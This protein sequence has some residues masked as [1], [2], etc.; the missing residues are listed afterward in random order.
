ML[1]DLINGNLERLGIKLP[2]PEPPVGSYVPWKRC[3]PTLWVSGQIP[4]IGGKPVLTGLLG[5]DVDVEDG[6]ECA[7]ICAVNAL[8]WLK[9]ATRGFQG[10]MGVLRLD[11]YVASVHS[12]HEQPAVI[13]GASDFIV[14]IFGEAGKHTRTA[15]GAAVLPLNS[16][17]MI[18]LVFEVEEDNGVAH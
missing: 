12:F 5:R 16:P 1:D 2:S 7:R 17:V 11:G 18:S 4:L 6:K 8:A 15:V 3:G 10:V 13:N 14:S 9:V